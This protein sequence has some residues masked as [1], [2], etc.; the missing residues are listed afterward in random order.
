MTDKTAPLPDDF[1]EVILAA[2]SLPSA[3]PFNIAER[4]PIKSAACTLFYTCPV[5]TLHSFRC[6]ACP[7]SATLPP[8]QSLG[9]LVSM[10]TTP[11]FLKLW[12]V[13]LAATDGTIVGELDHK[14]RISFERATELY[15]ML[16]QEDTP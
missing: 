10:L 12:E 13:R 7:L 15:N 4:T 8:E 14:L 2:G 3:G 9:N 11:Q 6:A 1:V 16:K 5:M